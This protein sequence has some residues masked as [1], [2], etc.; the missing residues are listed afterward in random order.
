LNRTPNAEIGPKD[1]LEIA[2]RPQPPTAGSE[3]TAHQISQ[4]IRCFG[5]SSRDTRL[6][7]FVA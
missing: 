7:N 6:V 4:G 5:C 2:P 1:N 3:E